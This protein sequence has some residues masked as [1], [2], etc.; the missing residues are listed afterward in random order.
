MFMESVAGSSWNQWPD[1]TGIRRRLSVLVD[2]YRLR[3][4]ISAGRTML[5]YAHIEKLLEDLRT[6]KVEMT[7]Q[8]G[9][10]HYRLHEGIIAGFVEASSK[11]VASGTFA[12]RDEEGCDQDHRSMLKITFGQAMT[13]MFLEDQSI[14][15][16]LA[17]VV[18]MKHGL[19]QA[20]ARYC[21]SHES[22]HETFDGICARVGFDLD[23]KAPRTVRSAKEKLRDDAAM[24]ATMGIE[25]RTNGGVHR[26]SGRSKP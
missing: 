12:Q 22:V 3:K 2:P 19:S 4:A 20:I 13:Q 1:A 5:P 11:P 15:Y 26:K 25:V 24:L 21:L 18:S 14:H 8:D 23:G 6:A 17:S 9:N 16:P 10:R 7:W